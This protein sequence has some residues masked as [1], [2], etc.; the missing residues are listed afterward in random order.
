M[1]IATEWQQRASDQLSVNDR[2]RRLALRSLNLMER[3]ANF[4]DNHYDEGKHPENFIE[5]F[6]VAMTALNPENIDTLSRVIDRTI[7]TDFKV[8]SQKYNDINEVAKEM[9]RLGYKIVP[10]K[11]VEAGAKPVN[12]GY[13]KETVSALRA[14]LYNEVVGSK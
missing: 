1:T 3:A 4:A 5:Y 7:H 6:R 9:Y 10:K 8:S 13:S 12:K 11:Q 2:V 14:A